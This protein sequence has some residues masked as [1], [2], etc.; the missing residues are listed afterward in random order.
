MYYSNVNCI[1]VWS[2]Q[3]VQV[4]SHIQVVGEGGGGGPVAG[5]GVIFA[6]LGQFSKEQGWGHTYLMQSLSYGGHL[7]QTD[8]DQR[9]QW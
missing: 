2:V 1:Y 6:F 9:G 3:C 7:L 8:P 5:G 4:V